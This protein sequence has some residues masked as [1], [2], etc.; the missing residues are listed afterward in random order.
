MSIPEKSVKHETSRVEIPTNVLCN[1]I[2][3]YKGD[4]ETLVAFLTNCQNALELA[5]PT[6]KIVLLK[7][8]LS[9]LEGK[10]QIASACKVFDDF[11]QL[12]TFLMQNFGERKHYNHL[13]LDLQSCRH[14]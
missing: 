4:R 14:D 10:A 13:L 1:F 7:F 11:N 9:R 6:Q 12:N 3:P 5:S 8:I 2:N